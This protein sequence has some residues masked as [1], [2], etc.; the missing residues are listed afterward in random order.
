MPKL[1]MEKAPKIS[2]VRGGGWQ[3]LEW[4]KGGWRP[5]QK[6]VCVHTCVHK[7]MHV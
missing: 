1:S 4:S 5:D 3:E 6:R 2:E 7:C